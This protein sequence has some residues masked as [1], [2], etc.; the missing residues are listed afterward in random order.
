MTEALAITGLVAN[1]SIRVDAVDNCRLD[2]K[3]QVIKFIPVKRIQKVFRLD[4]RVSGNGE[5]LQTSV[6]AF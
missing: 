2:E 4:C 5:S 1:I 3:L 6:A